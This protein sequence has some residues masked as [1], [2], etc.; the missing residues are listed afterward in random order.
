ML[1]AAYCGRRSW[2][3]SAPCSLVQSILPHRRMDWWADERISVR[4]YEW[5]GDHGPAFCAAETTAFY[6]V[7][8]GE[9]EISFGPATQHV[10]TTEGE[11]CFVL[12]RTPHVYR[13]A[14]GTRFV[15]VDFAAGDGSGAMHAPLSR[16]EGRA[17]ADAFESPDPARLAAAHAAALGVS[18]RAS[19]LALSPAHDTARMLTVKHALERGLA[20]PILLGDVARTFRLAPAVLSRAFRANFGGTPSEYVRLL[21][22]ERFLRSL[23]RARSEAALTRAAFDAGFGD[24]PTFCRMTSRWFGAPPSRLVVGET[25]NAPKPR[26]VRMEHTLPE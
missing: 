11:A 19:R 26:A 20:E 24:Y 10:R 7:L 5:T 21:R 1:K 6:A 9:L 13:V 8:A 17:F 12:A 25:S 23:R 2:A 18:S 16:R 14:A 3:I 15:A 22:M 4:R